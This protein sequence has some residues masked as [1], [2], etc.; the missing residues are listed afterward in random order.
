MVASPEKGAREQTPCAVILGTQWLVVWPHL[1]SVGGW[2]SS[3][4][5]RDFEAKI[6]ALGSVTGTGCSYAR[7]I[8]AKDDAG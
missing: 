1:I 7:L 5:L 6:L 8:C 4:R 2:R 3:V